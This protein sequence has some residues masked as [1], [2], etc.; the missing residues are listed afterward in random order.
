ML[1]LFIA[2]GLPTET[3][4]ET[5]SAAPTEEPGEAPG[6]NEELGFF[7]QFFD[8]LV[9]LI[10]PRDEF[11]QEEYD[12]LDEKLKEKLPYMVYVDTI[13]KF[14][15]TASYYDN[16]EK[17]AEVM[18]K[19]RLMF[20][21]EYGA[22]ER[23][24]KEFE[25]SLKDENMTLAQYKALADAYV[26]QVTTIVNI[27]YETKRKFYYYSDNFIEAFKMSPRE[28][29][30]KPLE[31]LFKIL[32][33]RSVFL[34]YLTSKSLC[35]FKRPKSNADA[36][37]NAADEDDTDNE[38]EYLSWWKRLRNTKQP[39]FD[40][41]TKLL[42]DYS[43]KMDTHIIKA[44]AINAIASSAVY[45]DNLDT[46]F[47]ED[48][49]DF[50]ADLNDNS[51]EKGEL[52]QFYAFRKSAKNK[53]VKN[54][55]R[56]NAEKEKKAI[57]HAQAVLAS[58]PTKNDYAKTVEKRISDFE[59]SIEQKRKRLS[60]SVQDIEALERK[61]EELKKELPKLPAEFL[62]PTPPNY[63]QMPLED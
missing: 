33:N 35:F 27:E 56:K 37:A 19:G 13:G 9:H 46:D 12:K 4:T 50:L 11:F 16:P 52:L 14:K 32:D 40:A 41:D 38:R 39:G 18:E 60:Y 7:A 30:P 1:F 34:D 61:L 57:E 3:P 8:G 21:I 5:P 29:V 51:K 54:R 43:H 49:S 59:L 10:V 47:T 55:K 23:V 45:A 42:R 53:T 25:L 36:A 58:D 31:R 22:D 15:D 24:K 48:L 44:K 17:L 2:S 63:T 20:Y 6:D 28:K 26:P 62:I